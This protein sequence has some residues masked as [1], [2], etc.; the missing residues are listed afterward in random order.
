M[1]FTVEETHI[2][3][4]KVIT[5]RVF[6]DSRGYFFESFR[7][8]SFKEAGIE[9]DFVQSNESMSS[10]NTLRGI[11]YQLAPH[12]QG[13]LVRVVTGAAL[14]VAVDLRKDSPTFGQWFSIELSGENKKL[15]YIPP[16]LGHGFVTLSD[17]MLFSYMCTSEY[18]RESERGII[19]NDPALNIDWKVTE[20]LLSDKD[21]VLPQL[22]KAEI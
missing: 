15:L 6:E 21:M 13:K 14:D 3:G 5:P 8:S 19:W 17:T 18:N 22:D 4:V 12:A 9:E 10:R 20:P 2:S 16:G 1:N 11:H 7:S